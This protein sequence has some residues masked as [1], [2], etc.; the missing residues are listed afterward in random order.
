M[1]AGNIAGAPPEI[2]P[3]I[4][5]IVNY[6]VWV[7]DDGAFHAR[8]EGKLSAAARRNGCVE[9]LADTDWNALVLR[10]CGNRLRAERLAYKPPGFLD[11][12]LGATP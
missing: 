2:D 1:Q 12:P 6:E 7:D 5:R 10:A 8:Y 11:L 9:E 3:R 4:H